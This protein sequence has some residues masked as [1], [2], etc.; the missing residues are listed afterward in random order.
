MSSVKLALNDTLGAAFLGTIATSCF[1]GITIVQTYIYFKRSGRDSLFLR[2]LVFSLWLLDSLHLALVVH[3][4]YYYAVTN[5]SDARVLA[6]PTWSI[7]AQIVVTGV[8]DLTVRGLV[9][10]VS[11]TLTFPLMIIE[12]AASSVIEFGGAVS[13]LT[14]FGGSIAFAVKSF[15]VPTF[16]AFSEIAD[17]LYVSLGA[18]VV[19]DMLIAGAMTV[20]LIKC[21]TGFSKTDSVIRTLIIYSINTGALTG[22]CALL[23]LVTYATMPDNFIFIAFYFVLPKLFLNSLLATLNAREALRGASPSG[24]VSVPLSHASYTTHMSF[25][26]RSRYSQSNGPHK[27]EVHTTTDTKTDASPHE[28]SIDEGVKVWRVPYGPTGERPDSDVLV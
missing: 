28:D 18:G 17:I 11:Y 25:V 27:G 26:D 23:C 8:S 22:L 19:A 14:V 6:V 20:V 10:T 7:L 12:R 2:F 15:G 16:A 9:P 1:Y 5:F 4:I 13:S 3:A 24:M 21:R